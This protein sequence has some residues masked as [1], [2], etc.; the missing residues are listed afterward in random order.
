MLTSCRASKDRARFSGH[1]EVLKF[2]CKEFW[3]EVFRKS[4]D[5]LKTNQKG[6]FILVDDKFR[7]L[8]HLSFDESELSREN[9]NKILAFVRLP[10]G[11]IKGALAHF[12]ITLLHVLHL[13]LCCCCAA[14]VVV[15]PNMQVS[16]QWSQQRCVR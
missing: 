12:G 8:A 9:R 4:I 16:I 13:L 3:N 11:L 1:L 5:H 10:C 15:A 14:A 6:I 7:W 2:I